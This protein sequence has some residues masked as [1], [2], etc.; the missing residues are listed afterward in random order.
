[1]TEKER[2]RDEGKPLHVYHSVYCESQ[3][4]DNGFESE[5]NC[6]MFS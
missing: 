5:T 3:C 4:L 1:M 6:D 2:E